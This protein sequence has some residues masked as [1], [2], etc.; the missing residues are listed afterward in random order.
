MS[1]QAE[2]GGVSTVTGSAPVASSG[3]NTPNITLTQPLP[4][5]NGGTG[6]AAQNFVDLTTA[7]SIA[8]VKSLSNKLFLST[9]ANATQAV[10]GLYAQN[11][12]PNNAN[13]ANGDYE[14]RGD[15]TAAGN[16]LVYHRETG[17]WVAWSPAGGATAPLTLTGTGGNIPLTLAASATQTVDFFQI[18]NVTPVTVFKVGPTG[19]V[20]LTDP[21]AVNSLLIGNAQLGVQAPSNKAVTLGTSGTDWLNINGSRLALTT[22][23]FYPSTDAK[24]VQTACGIFA[25]TGA[26]NN[27]NGNN[28]DIDFN[29]AGGAL[30][31][32]Y[33]RR[34]GTWTGIV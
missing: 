16:T 30:T 17:V 21:S 13:G 7:Q 19:N 27:A 9:D 20:T 28:G 14:L 10:A 4:V 23:Q 1:Y 18:N 34:A 32:M 29:G 12:V 31:T 33:Q 25:G 22:G 3:G 26:P 11:G 8:G 24:A 5:A 6:A 15:G 2:A